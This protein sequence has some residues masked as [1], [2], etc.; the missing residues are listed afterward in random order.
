VLGCKL[1]AL[2]ALDLSYRQAYNN[3]KNSELADVVSGFIGNMDRVVAVCFFPAR[4]I[5]L[6]GRFLS[7]W[8]TA[9][10][11]VTDDRDLVHRDYEKYLQLRPDIAAK[12]APF[13]PDQLT[14]LDGHGKDL[15]R[16]WEEGL[17]MVDVMTA[18]SGE[19]L[20]NAVESMLD[21]M[22]VGTWTAFEILAGDL[23]VAVLNIHPRGLALLSGDEKRISIAAKALGAAVRAV[24]GEKREGE[25]SVRLKDIHD[26]TRGDYNL[27][28]RMGDLLKYRFEFSNLYEIRR[29]YSL[30]FDDK[31]IDRDVVNA[32][33]TSLAD[34]AIDEL[35]A[36]RNVI[37]HN[38]GIV[39]D[40][41]L[42]NV[43]GVSTVP[44][45]G[46]GQLLRLDGEAVR[47]LID[48]VVACCLKLLGT[49]DDW[50]ATE[51]GGIG[52]WS[53]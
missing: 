20:S 27:G 17:C 52:S 11:Q 23:W 45:L 51:S 48:P 1:S 43:K 40:D 19:Y 15:Q 42:K 25:K 16:R 44:R 53:I 21:S 7:R 2:A 50:L 10:S 9:I 34:N 49:L 38:R 8:N 39:D 28:S 36:V 46:K 32:V 47:S 29:A 13:E 6:S 5:N 3:L 4:L 26:V 30:A 35:S 31:K 24:D 37:V 18:K 12:T 33:D 22:A 41:Y 14:A